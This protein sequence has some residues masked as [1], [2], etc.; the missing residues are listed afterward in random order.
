MTIE[1]KLVSANIPQNSNGEYS[2]LDA[3]CHFAKVCVTQDAKQE[4]EKVDGMDREKKI[5]FVTSLLQSG[6]TSLFQHTNFHFY[7]SGVSRIFVSHFLHAH[8]FYNTEQVS[9]RFVKQDSFYIPDSFP[10]KELETAYNV[11]TEMAPIWYNDLIEE[12]VD[13][14]HEKTKNMSEHQRKFINPEQIACEN[15][16]YFLPMCSSTRL[17]YTVN[18]LTLMRM[19]NVAKLVFY[20]NPEVSDFVDKL[21]K[22][23]STVDPDI[24]LLLEKSL[25]HTK[26]LDKDNNIEKSF[27]EDVVNKRNIRLFKSGKFE[28]IYDAEALSFYH[29][30][31]RN[32]E[33]SIIHDP[34]RIQF[35]YKYPEKLNDIFFKFSKMAS[36]AAFCQ[37][38]RHR[39]YT[40]IMAPWGPDF[41]GLKNVV[42]TYPPVIKQMIDMGNETVAGAIERIVD[43]V[44]TFKKVAINK[45]IATMYL[46]LLPMGSVI[47]YSQIAPISAII[48]KI[49]Q[50][51][52]LHAQI[53]IWE[54]AKLEAALLEYFVE[55][56]RKSFADKLPIIG[57]IKRLF[58]GNNKMDDDTAEF[59]MKSLGAICHQRK[60]CG[61]SPYCPEGT[62]FCGVTFWE[63][64]PQKVD[65]MF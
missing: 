13:L 54:I 21:A 48:H 18:F 14:V 8:S 56:S 6:H 19:Y 5:K 23:L 49:G 33:A 17:H 59:I 40:T 52:C 65:R 62:R 39:G 29:D 32:G 64:D 42:F 63:E 3:I 9:Q 36:Y 35:A 41:F 4:C 38:Q 46:Y 2:I 25:E 57:G 26:K 45:D 12:I 10:L 30:A 61:I 16:R 31:M 34:L 51:L 7:I 58:G 47:S 44:S 55:T 53:E 15:A 37:E 22:E 43:I 50:R 28:H 60:N 20:R 24:V 11:V 27:T 1:V